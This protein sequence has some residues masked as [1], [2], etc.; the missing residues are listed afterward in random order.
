[1]TGHTVVTAVWAVVLAAALATA[2]HAG[3][4]RVTADVQSAAGA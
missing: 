1:M 4:S 2:A 3:G